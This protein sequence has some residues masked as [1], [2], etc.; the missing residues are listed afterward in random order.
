MSSLD[1]EI[2]ALIKAHTPYFEPLDNGKV[3]CTLNGHE[4]APRKD[5][6]DQFVK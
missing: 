6:I 4:F 1:K 2:Q 3:K 5:V